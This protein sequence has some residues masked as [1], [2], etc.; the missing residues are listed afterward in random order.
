[1]TNIGSFRR[2]GCDRDV[3]RGSR[4][5]DSISPMHAVAV[6]LMSS[7]LARQLRGQRGFM[8]AKAKK[9]KPPGSPSHANHLSRL[10]NQGTATSTVRG[11]MGTAD[12]AGSRAAVLPPAVSGAEIGDQACQ[13][14]RFCTSGR[15]LQPFRLSE[16]SGGTRMPETR[17]RRVRR[18]CPCPA[19]AF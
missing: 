17:V 13:P 4:W 1:L 6:S 14:Q 5:G 15:T 7:D 12:D 10:S 8:V 19:G 3:T 2:S 9:T 11:L 18:V 16:A